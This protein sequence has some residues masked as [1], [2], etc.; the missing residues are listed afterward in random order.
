MQLALSASV[1]KAQGQVL[2]VAG[3][4]SAISRGLTAA[5]LTLT[6]APLELSEFGIITLQHLK[7]ADTLVKYL[8]KARELK[9]EDELSVPSGK[10]SKIWHEE[11]QPSCSARLPRS[12]KCPRD[13][14]IQFGPIG[15]PAEDSM[16]E[17]LSAA[18]S[19]DSVVAQAKLPLL[20]QFAS[21][22]STVPCLLSHCSSNCY[23]LIRY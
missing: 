23:V 4:L 2:R 1:A 13:F 21:L 22:S 18:I 3:I 16:L 19:S 15:K 5:V 14:L 20:A 7:G 8:S 6:A 12:S 9:L 17:M 10:I 11:L